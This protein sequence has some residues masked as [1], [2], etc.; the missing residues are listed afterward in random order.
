VADII[1]QVTKYILAPLNEP[2][3][4]GQV[5]REHGGEGQDVPLDLNLDAIRQLD[6]GI[7]EGYQQEGEELLGCYRG[8]S[9]P[10]TITLFG[11]TLRRFFWAI[12]GR[13]AQTGHSFW[14]EDVESLAHL[15]V[16]KTWRHEQFHLFVDIQEH[17]APGQATAGRLMEEALASA[18]SWRQIHV[19]S[20]VKRIHQSLLRPF[21]SQ[22]YDY[23]RLPGYSDWPQY[24][25]DTLFQG[26]L[27]KFF[28]RPEFSFLESSGVPVG[29]LLVEQ[30]PVMDA[31]STINIFA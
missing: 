12:I 31:V 29:R 26:G 9:S 20:P 28:N 15:T 19:A 27:L 16:L 22:A 11:D 4:S 21:L 6:G 1:K 7:L 17:L 2:E 13:M 30:L 14:H 5:A 8:M 23:G 10:G 25:S 18:H 24:D 3:F